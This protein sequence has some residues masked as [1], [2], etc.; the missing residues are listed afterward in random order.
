[1][2]VFMIDYGVSSLGEAVM[3]CMYQVGRLG[4]QNDRCLLNVAH[5][6]IA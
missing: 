3:V 2:S 6:L 5:F 4:L 1:M